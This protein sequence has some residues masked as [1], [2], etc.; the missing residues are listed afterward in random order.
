MRFVALILVIVS[1]LLTQLAAQENPT[2]SAVLEE[3]SIPFPPSIPH[4][5]SKITSVAVSDDDLEFVIAYCLDTLKNELR[6]LLLLT[7]CHKITG[8]WET[9]CPIPSLS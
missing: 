4:L 7:R 2:L 3:H 6:A 5:N 8:K 9:I 1:A